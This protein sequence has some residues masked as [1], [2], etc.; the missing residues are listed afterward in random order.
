[1]E[2]EFIDF[3]RM[4]IGAEECTEE[5]EGLGNMKKRLIDL[6]EFKAA[7]MDKMIDAYLVDAPLTRDER[8][9]KVI[10]LLRIVIEVDECA[11]IIEAE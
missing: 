4:V 10:D 8:E 9:E 7:M 5:K 2:R 1:M 11:E 6:N 3:L